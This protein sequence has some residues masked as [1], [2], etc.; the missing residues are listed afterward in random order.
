MNKYQR[1][2]CCLKG[3]V[4]PFALILIL[5]V[6]HWFWNWRQTFYIKD[7]DMYVRI[8][9]IPFGDATM[10]FSRSETFGDDYVKC[11][12]P[13]E[14]VGMKI[15]Y[16]PPCTICVSGASGVKQG[17]FRIIEFEKKE[18]IRWHEKVPDSLAAE[19]YTE[20]SDSTFLVNPSFRFS[21]YDYFTGFRLTDNNGKIIFDTDLAI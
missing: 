8:E 14:I 19:F 20:Y 15:Y 2:S 3:C 17:I 13:S 6:I 11:H 16:V 1:R 5:T 4:M 12:H 21:I 9:K 10:Y 7:I 18:E